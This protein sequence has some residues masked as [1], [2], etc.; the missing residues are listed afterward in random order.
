MKLIHCHFFLLAALICVP[1]AADDF[2]SLFDGTHLDHWIRTNTP[3][4]TWTVHSGLLM[5]T[6]KPY[7]EIRTKEMFENF[8]LE[9]EWRHVLPRGNAGIFVWADDIPSRGVPFH[10]GI[11]VQVLELGYGASQH[12][13]SDGDIFPIHGATMEPDNGR[14]GSRAFPTE[15]RVKPT[16]EWN[17][18]RITCN[19]GDITLAVNGKVVTSGRNCQP[20]KGYICLE[21][22]GGVVHYRNIRIQRLPST[23]A[24][25]QE[26]AIADRGYESVYSG[27]TLTG[28]KTAARQLD[29]AKEADGWIVDD[30]KL[31]HLPWAPERPVR[32]D[33]GRASATGF[34]CDFRLAGEQSAARF[35]LLGAENADGILDTGDSRLSEHLSDHGQWNR[36]E[37]DTADGKLRILLNGKELPQVDAG[38][39]EVTLIL[40]AD[41]A[42]D[43][44]NLFVRSRPETPAARR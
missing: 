7:G 4:E 11:E 1:A 44:A 5:C 15:A 3:E 25:E 28:W 14:G 29:N 16:P 9:L 20:R 33:C 6:G 37:Y 36:L 24:G 32:L 43:Y 34:L 42:V 23:N 31:R 22:E 26:T 39:N 10:R 38:Q 17:H 27:L 2:E 41:G 21:S 13:T 12:H 18:F 8:I 35:S 30:W 19:D 40:E